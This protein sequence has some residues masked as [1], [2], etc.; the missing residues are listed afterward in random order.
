MHHS[1]ERQKYSLTFFAYETRH[2]TH[3]I[4]SELYKQSNCL[5]AVQSESIEFHAQICSRISALGASARMDYDYLQ[6]TELSW[7]E[8][9][10]YAGF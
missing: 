9:A 2:P 8:Q 5:G 1:I 6:L 3:S 4:S 7:Y 10:E